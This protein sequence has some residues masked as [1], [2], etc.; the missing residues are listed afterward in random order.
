SAR[1]AGCD[2]QLQLRVGIWQ[3]APVAS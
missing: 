2:R 3:V 1:E